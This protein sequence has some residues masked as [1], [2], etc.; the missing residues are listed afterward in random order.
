MMMYEFVYRMF[1]VMMH[2][3]DDDDAM[4]KD[5]MRKID[6]IREIRVHYLRH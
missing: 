6:S 4:F 1:D 2:V 5:I 3:Y